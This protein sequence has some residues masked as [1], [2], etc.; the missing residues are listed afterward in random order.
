VSACFPPPRAV[1]AAL[2]ALA[3]HAP[4]LALDPSDSP[5][6]AAPARPRIGLAL[7]GGGARGLAHV[8]ALSALEELRVPIDCIAGTSM[9]SIV[10]GLYAT[11]MSP[12]E[13]DRAMG[14]VDWDNLF[15]DRPPR[16][17]LTYRRKQDDVADLMDA[18][19]GIKDGRVVLPR[20]LIAGQKI[21][22]LLQSLTLR[23]AGVADFGALPIPF[24]AVATDLGTGKAVVLRRGNLGDALRASMSLP[25]VVAPIEIDGRLL[26]DGGL[27][28]NLPVDTAR[29][30]C[31]DVV[32]AIDIS[33][34]LDAPS[35]IRSVTDVTRQVTGMMTQGNIE[36]QAEAAN[37]LIRPDLT[38]VSSGD[39]SKAASIVPIGRAAVLAQRA[40]LEKYALS[41]EAYTEHL[42]QLHAAL[43]K[44]TRIAAVRIDAPSDVDPRVLRSRVRTQPDSDLDL[45]TLQSDL[46]RLYE[47]GVFER[48]DFT[49]SPAADGFDLVIRASEKPWGP[50]SLRFGI[51]FVN[52]FQGDTD[53]NLRGRYTRFL[54][55][56]LGG[57]WRTDAQLGTNR[58][59]LTELYQP[60]AFSTIWFVAPSFDFQSSVV[61]VF[62]DEHRVAEYDVRQFSGAL[63]LGAALGR[64]G[65]ARLGLLHGRGKAH[66]GV[67]ASDLP[68]LDVA[69]GAWVG[70]L[71]VDRLDE[72]HFPGH[73][74][75][76]G[77][78]A[79]LARRDLGSDV[80]YD[81]LEGFA[82]QF[83]SRGRNTVF[84]GL[85]GG[86]NLGSDIPFYTQFE[87]GG[88]FSLSG[89]RE[90]ELHGQ[91]FGTARVG[92]YRT[93]GRL[94]RK[95][96][97]AVYYGAWTEA[98]NAWES[99][100][101]AS[102][103]DLRYTG[104][105]GFGVDTF[106][107]PIYLAYGR[108]NGGPDA[109]YF[110]VGRSFTGQGFFGAN[111]F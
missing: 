64:S 18:E 82:T 37:L 39:Y 16:R 19:V 95:A 25:G 71:K 7:S 53:F 51:N 38:G 96:G 107:G 48:V 41:E 85:G 88:L 58:R 20:G 31:A 46:S 36:A 14:T 24:G 54:V 29:E 78:G 45:S 32:I 40:D 65:E 56:R 1:A 93:A 61:D 6:P 106:L 11:G 89:F 98:G 67:G 23:A 44:P 52:D 77:L 9:G 83:M 33:T 8:G 43:R 60:L 81:K 17:E 63:A 42:S 10:G 86:T 15:S 50:R 13:I 5:I 102:L 73:G 90:G 91:V 57:E 68:R 72:A 87:L 28:R 109:I 79:F 34:P 100:D 3:V 84:M 76:A 94:S 108:A 70:T 30:I 80:S 35:A 47:V 62:Q 55:N 49:L 104:T 4:A 27:V 92:Y 2:V 21:G 26:A 74:I 97:H 75:S 59:I 103:S 22:F 111:N 69:V 12:D 110:A 105:I 101:E 99:T 66:V